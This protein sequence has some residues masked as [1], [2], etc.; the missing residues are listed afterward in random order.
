MDDS[1]S[2]L[3]QKATLLAG[4]RLTPG[5][6]RFLEALGSRLEAEEAWQD[7]HD[8]FLPQLRSVQPG[9]AL[10]GYVRYML[11][12]A[13]TELGQIEEALP[14]LERAAEIRPDFPFVH[15]LL[16]RC[17]R[18]LRRLPEALKASLT[19]C[20]LA[21]DFPW[22]WL[23]TGELQLLLGLPR[24]ALVSFQRGLCAQKLSNPGDLTLFERGF[25]R[26][27]EEVINIERQALAA[28]LWP[29]RPPLAPGQPLEPLEELE[30]SL[31]QFRSMLDRVEA[32]RAAALGDASSPPQ[33]RP[34]P[35]NS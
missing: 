33:A 31:H 15:H 27:H 10:D 2:P 34:K 11:G 25:A 22:G 16:A 8:H 29:D 35:S 28:E 1:P 23:E 32:R 30:L 21:A 4:L 18:R 20:S 26:A 19:C 5:D 17:Y 24:E 7:L 3:I 6:P 13:A 12:K 9:T 14:W